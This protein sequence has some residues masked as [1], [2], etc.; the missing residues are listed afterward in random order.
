MRLVCLLIIT[1]CFTA[2]SSSKK[3]A[4]GTRMKLV[5]S[6]EFNY[7][8]LPDSSKWGYNTG[9]NGWGNNELQYYTADDTLTAK[10]E[11]GYLLIITR[12]QKMENRE[13]ISARLLTKN[14]F[15][16]KYGRV[17]VSAKIPSAIG[18]WPAVW[19]LGNDIDKVN[20][21]ACGEIDIVEHRGME[22]NK[23]FGTLH[24]PGHSGGNGNGNTI[25]ISTAT[26]A[27]HQYAVEWDATSLNFYVDNELYHSV[28]NDNNIPF[29]HNF[30]I[31]VNMAIGGNFGGKV[32]PLFSSDKME[33]DY[34]RVFQKK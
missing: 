33:I 19:M 8:G 25:N 9:G 13:Y 18:T 31:L 6:D 11:N 28:A 15:D 26:T 16:F 23:I 30:F 20:W 27:F 2:C 4:N 29:N 32:D 1:I 7:K 24:Y 12:K 34:I 14:K 3:A 10:V 21:P 22:L 5:W 17:E